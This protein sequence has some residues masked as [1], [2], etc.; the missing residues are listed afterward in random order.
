[1]RQIAGENVTFYEDQKALEPELDKFNAVLE[2]ASAKTEE[3]RA[4]EGSELKAAIAE[5][6]QTVGEARRAYNK[7]VEAYFIQKLRGTNA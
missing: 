3:A 1:M 6:I 5:Y 7:A 2:A 4:S